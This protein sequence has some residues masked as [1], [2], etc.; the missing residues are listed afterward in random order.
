[1]LEQ[2]G[3]RDLLLVAARELAD[4]L[5]GVVALDAQLADPVP[6][7]GALPGELSRPNRPKAPSL[8]SVRLSAR[9]G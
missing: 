3:D 8:A 4:G 1:V 9:T 6:G 5:R 2:A 7:G